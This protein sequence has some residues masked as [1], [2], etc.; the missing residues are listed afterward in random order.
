MHNMLNAAHRVAI[1]F[2]SVAYQ[3]HNPILSS[4]PDAAANSDK[5]TSIQCNSVQTSV[6]AKGDQGAGVEGCALW[7]ALCAKLVVWCKVRRPS[8]FREILSSNCSRTVTDNQTE[9]TLSS[10]S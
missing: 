10:S 4:I 6:S 5:F 9:I 8:N 1:H 3:H 2:N 7:C